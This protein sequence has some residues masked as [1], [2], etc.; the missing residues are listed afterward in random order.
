VASGIEDKVVAAAV[1]KKSRLERA[2][3]ASF[4]SLVI[5]VLRALVKTTG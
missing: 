2:I 4:S 1:F 5:D 3:L